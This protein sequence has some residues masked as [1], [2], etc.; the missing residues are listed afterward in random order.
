MIVVMDRIIAQVTFL[1][2]SQLTLLN[3]GGQGVRT[4]GEYFLV[5]THLFVGIRRNRVLVLLAEAI[6]V[7]EASR[8]NERY[9]CLHRHFSLPPRLPHIPELTTPLLV[10][11]LSKVSCT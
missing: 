10:L 8:R 5:L 4:G 6:T 1:P 7:A 3:N 11:P 9:C 2:V